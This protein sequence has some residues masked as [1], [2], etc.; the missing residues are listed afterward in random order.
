MSKVLLSW[1][2]RKCV[3]EHDKAMKVLDLLHDAEVFETKWRKGEDDTYHVY[4]PDPNEILH[5]SMTVA[6]LPAELYRVAKLAGRPE[7]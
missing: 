3:L 4:S 7:E 2:G 5:N 1:H 6:P